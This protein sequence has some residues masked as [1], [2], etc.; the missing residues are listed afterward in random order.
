MKVRLQDTNK[1][2][3]GSVCLV[4]RFFD[5]ETR[6]KLQVASQW[7]IINQPHLSSPDGRTGN[8]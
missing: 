2:K 4:C 5:A 6:R 7:K 1:T 8:N 3:L